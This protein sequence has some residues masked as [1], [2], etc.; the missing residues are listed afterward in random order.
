MKSLYFEKYSAYWNMQ[1]KPSKNKT[2]A[3]IETHI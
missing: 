3:E 2:T 1:Q